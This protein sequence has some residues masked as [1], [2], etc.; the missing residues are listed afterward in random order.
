MP[1]PRHEWV[2]VPGARL[3]VLIEGTGAPVIVPSG[4]GAEYYRNTL[5]PALRERFQFVYV[6]LRATGDSTGTLEDAT[7]ASHADDL[8]GVRQGLGFERVAVL[9]HSNHGCIALE[10]GL[11]RGAR[12][13]AILAV[14][15]APDFR[16]AF[17][18]GQERWKR[19]ASPEAQAALDARM[20]RAGSLLEAGDSRAMLEAYLATAPL[21][22]RDP[23]FDPRP[24]WGDSPPKGMGAYM[25]WM[26]AF[27]AGWNLVPRL[28]EVAPPVLALSGRFDYL[29]P[30]ELWEESVALLPQGRLVVFE[31]SAHNPQYEEREAFAAEVIPFLEAAFAREAPGQG[32]DA[33]KATL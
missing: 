28:H 20:A 3:H 31:Q 6:D 2:E 12:A 26:M 23:S 27:G 7:F 17:A 5:P 33:P 22:W 29:C 15:T 9:G 8:E 30:V 13:A 16:N 4:A 1:G 32:G 18:L 11:R 14:G 25:A 24:L 10:Y 21:G 19:E